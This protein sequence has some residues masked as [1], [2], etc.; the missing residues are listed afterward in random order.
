[1]STTFDTATHIRTFSVDSAD[2]QIDD[3]RRRIPTT[4]LPTR[5][6]VGGPS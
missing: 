3:L 5:E 6:L 2:E 1:M 4:R